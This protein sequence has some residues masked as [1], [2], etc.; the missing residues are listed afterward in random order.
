MFWALDAMMRWKEL[1]GKLEETLF[2]GSV[3]GRY[4]SNFCVS[5]DDFLLWRLRINLVRGNLCL[6]QIHKYIW[7]AD[8]CPRNALA[9]KV[10]KRTRCRV[11][12]PDTQR[13]PYHFDSQSIT[14]TTRDFI[15]SSCLSYWHIFDTICT[16]HIAKRTVTITISGTALPPFSL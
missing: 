14:C 10:V 3:T 13:C 12:V 2:Y 5:D 8:F 11:K 1:K 7:S 6:R 4:G 9:Y 15:G 16:S